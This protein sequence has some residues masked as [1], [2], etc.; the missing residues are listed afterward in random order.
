MRLS[1]ADNFIIRELA[2]R[3]Y[4]VNV[5]RRGEYR[6]PL[7]LNEIGADIMLPLINGGDDQDS[8]RYIASEYGIDISLARA[9]VTSFLD[10]MKA[11]GLELIP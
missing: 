9:D 1:N 7:I 8:V 5:A 4:L 10:K 11:S 3:F 2:G 6:S